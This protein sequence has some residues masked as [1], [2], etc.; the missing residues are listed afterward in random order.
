M[1]A[2]NTDLRVKRRIM[3]LRGILLIYAVMLLLVGVQTG[4]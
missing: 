1:K 4:L 3:K 2:P